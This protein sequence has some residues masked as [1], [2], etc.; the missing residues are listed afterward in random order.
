[1]VTSIEEVEAA[2]YTSLSFMRYFLF[3]SFSWCHGLAATFDYDTPW[4]FRQLI[5]KHLRSKIIKLEFYLTR[6]GNMFHGTNNQ[7]GNAKRK[8][9]VLR[10]KH[11][12]SHTTV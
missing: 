7:S 12:T 5:E 3:F 1:M 10:K 6:S 11:F 9:L 2:L 8:S 4:T